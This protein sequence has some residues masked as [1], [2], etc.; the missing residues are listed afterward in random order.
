M[1]AAVPPSLVPRQLC[2]CHGCARR[3][4]PEHTTGR[5]FHGCCPEDKAGR[6]TGRTSRRGAGRASVRTGTLRP[7]GGHGTP[8]S[9]A[10]LSFLALLAG[11]GATFN[12]LTLRHPGSVTTVMGV[13]AFSETQNS[14]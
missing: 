10:Y 7:P 11:G 12:S 4:G 6:G 9:A 3:A 5:T 14:W 8:L 2:V 1:S 13:P